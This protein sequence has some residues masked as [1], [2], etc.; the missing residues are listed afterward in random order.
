[1]IS[2]QKLLYKYKGPD[3][4]ISKVEMLNQRPLIDENELSNFY[5]LYQPL[6]T[7]KIETQTGDKFIVKKFFFNCKN[8]ILYANEMINHASNKGISCLKPM[9]FNG[10]VFIED[11]H[12]LYQVYPFL[13]IE[14]PM[15]EKENQ[16]L[17]K[18]VSKTLNKLHE[19]NA[20]SP[21]SWLL[22][23][24]DLK[25]W[26]HLCKNYFS[27]NKIADYLYSLTMKYYEAST[28]IATE[29][30]EWVLSHR[31]IRPE[32]ILTIKKNSHGF[33]LIDWDLAG[34]IHRYIELIGV[35]FNF[36]NPFIEG[37]SLE[38]IK[39]FLCSYQD[40]SLS[41]TQ[42][43]Q[44]KYIDAS[45]GTWLAWLAYLLINYKFSHKNQKIYWQKQIKE[46]LSMIKKLTALSNDI[47][48]N[49]VQ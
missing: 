4:T 45:L 19:A 27:D 37:T 8:Q 2:L 39:Q 33:V 9:S 42:L 21:N 40:K 11:E 35:I 5:L 23:C 17:L 38:I 48:P 36:I 32:N 20:T 13:K 6:L 41:L 14:K 31:D 43:F 28:L 46:N 34:P 1:M 24:P 10:Q 25:T 12:Y 3:F 29:A 44:K 7:A 15:Q 16:H 18:Y 22:T 30:M 49:K 47:K 26:L